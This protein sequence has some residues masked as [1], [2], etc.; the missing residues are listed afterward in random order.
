MI[1]FVQKTGLWFSVLLLAAYAFKPDDFWFQQGVSEAEVRDVLVF[2]RQDVGAERLSKEYV[3]K[4]VAYCM[5]SKGFILKQG[6]R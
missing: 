3:E 6:Y 2:C 4:M 5:K 1:Q